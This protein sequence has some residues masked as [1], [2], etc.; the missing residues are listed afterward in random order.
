MLSRVDHRLRLD[1]A[2]LGD[3]FRH[4]GDEIRPVAPPAQGH[5]GHVRAVGFQ[6]NALERNAR[7]HFGGLSGV[8]EGHAAAQPDVKTDV[9]ELLRGFKA[10]GKAVHHAP[11]P[12]PEDQL[13]TIGVRLAVVHDHRQVKLVGQDQLFKKSSC[14]SFGV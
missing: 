6:Q 4:V 3:L 10:A 7:R 1:P 12:V 8:F 14:M 5:G 9:H 13:H 11:R 2:Q